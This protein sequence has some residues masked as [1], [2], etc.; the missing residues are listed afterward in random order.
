MDAGNG[1]PVNA[2]FCVTG[3]TGYIGSWLVCSLLRRGFTVH[4]TARDTGKA[5]YLL[6]LPNASNRLKIFKSD[7][8]EEGSFDEAVKGCV[9]VFHVAASMELSVE[10]EEAI[11]AMMETAVKG[12]VNVL[13][14]CLRSKSVKKVLFTSSISTISARE[15]GR[16]WRSVV[17]E[18]SVNPIDLVLNTKPC[19]W[20][21]VVSKIMTEEKAFQFAK[22]N[23]I[24][25]VSIIPPTVAGPF[26]TP[27]VPVSIKVLLSPLTGDPYLYPV[28]ITVHSRLGSVPLVHIEDLC[29]A[30]IFLMEK[31]SAE[32][33]YICSAGSST[34][35]Q[36]EEL[37]SE[38][39]SSFSCKRYTKESHD[40]AASIISSKKLTDLGFEF[41]HGIKGIV[42]QSIA[43]STEEVR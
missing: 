4:A 37:L 35:P 20:V 13:Q 23:G 5:S 10:H 32:G 41:K 9:G 2:T 33:R 24:N 16:G 31:D 39:Y 27:S 7:L 12:T 8:S 38:H 25:L 21:Y 15:E 14:A 36:L 18:S 1:T 26:L 43:S 19:G 42:E 34:L 3:S 17:D 22:E 29:N 6:S 30:Q 28:L 11:D 40:G